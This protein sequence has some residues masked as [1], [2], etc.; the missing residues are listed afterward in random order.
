M[1]KDRG[2]GMKG[3]KENKRIKEERKKEKRE[4]KRRGTAEKNEV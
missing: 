1:R 3:K 2:R 4:G